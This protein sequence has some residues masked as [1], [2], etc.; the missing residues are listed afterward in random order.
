MSIARFPSYLSS[1]PREHPVNSR[2]FE[3]CP[4]RY[5]AKILTD[6]TDWI[7]GFQEGFSIQE[8][9]GITGRKTN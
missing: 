5:F 1:E 2:S 7:F 3:L 4:D 9:A 6:F 8:T